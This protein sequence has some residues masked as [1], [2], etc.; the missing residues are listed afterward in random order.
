[1][2]DHARRCYV[3]G[4]LCKLSSV[5]RLLPI[6][7][8]AVAALAA[9]GPAT[10]ATQLGAST[11]ADQPCSA[12]STVVQDVTATGS[13]SYQVPP[14][15]GVVT[16]WSFNA[17]ATPGAR[18]LKLLAPTAASG[19]YRVAGESALETGTPNQ[20]N[21]FNTRI[22]VAGGELLGFF[23][24]T[25]DG[26]RSSA[27]SGNTVRGG[28][29]D[30]AAGTSFSAT[31]LFASS[32][33]LEVTA[34]VEPDGDGDGYG[35]ETQDGCPTEPTVFLTACEADLEVSLT[36]DPLALRLGDPI[37]YTVNVRNNGPTTARG[38]VV[39]L[40]LP[41]NAPLVSAT[42]GCTGFGTIRCD[43]GDI[44]AGASSPAYRIVARAPDPGEVSTTATATTT[45]RDPNP[46]ND[47]ATAV[48]SVTP[49]RFGGARLAR[50]PVRVK[51]G[52]VGIRVSCPIAARSC[53]G[54][55]D[56]VTA[57]RVR[58]KPRARPRKL[59]LGT[60]NVTLKGGQAKILKV[61][62][63]RTAARYLARVGKVRATASAVT[64]DAFSQG[65]IR[66]VPITVLAEL[67]ARRAGR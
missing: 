24:T 61:S 32:T 64:A 31:S 10:A 1:L 62:L 67:P 38:V 11:S 34:T 55:L 29:G 49:P 43:A 27:A 7:V 6:A 66:S 37:A 54:T 17:K 30:P 46:A 48:V 8:T 26:C 21:T 59:P 25:G 63:S 16:K 40:A 41:L 36:A 35:D 14:G 60:V 19:T 12:N 65:A 52:Q 56:L 57:S 42:E 20:V 51:R 28:A 58:T 15:A 50:R 45:T 2:A 4:V 3:E 18:K 39:A 53:T 9:A 44:V 22:P 33:L 47:S 13:P 5:R 23:T